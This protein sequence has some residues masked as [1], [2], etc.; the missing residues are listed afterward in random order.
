MIEPGMQPF[1]DP[2]ARLLARLR[3]LAGGQLLRR[4]RM[5]VVAVPP[6]GPHMRDRAALLDRLD[7]A[8]GVIGRIHAQV[9]LDLLRI[10]PLDDDGIEGGFSH[11]H[12]VAV[13]RF[14]HHG[15]WQ[16]V[17]FTPVTEFGPPLVAI[18][19]ILAG[20]V[21]AERGLDLRPVQALPVPVQSGQLLVVLQAGLPKA[22]ED[23]LALPQTEAVI[24]GARGAPLTRHGIPRNTGAH[25]VDDGGKH[26][27]IIGGWAS[28]FGMRR[29]FWDQGTHALPQVITDFP[30][31][32]SGHD[33][34]SF[35]AV[36]GFL[37]FLLILSLLSRF[38][39]KFQGG[40]L[41]F[42]L[43]NL[44]GLTTT[45]V[46][47]LFVREESMNRL[48]QFWQKPLSRVVLAAMLLVTLLV[49]E[50]LA[51]TRHRA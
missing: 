9:L 41:H 6:V 43:K 30:R 8:W 32:G 4:G 31:F 38:S 19:R 33:S 14:Q 21:A 51:S 34:C 29:A 45:F 22:L 25:Q 27:P 17:A 3:S 26:L 23:A 2:T 10:R 24:D 5:A 18:H 37:S 11:D 50:G 7:D 47:V 36:F 15:Q 48:T 42:Y 1:D 12:V 44:P 49:E 39:D 28:A 13:G 20:G 46:G 40:S 35:A 16:A